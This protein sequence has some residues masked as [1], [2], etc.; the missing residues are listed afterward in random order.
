MAVGAI[1]AAA[2][3]TRVQKSLGTIFT[4]GTGLNGTPAH[5]VND[6]EH[7]IEETW[8]IFQKSPLIGYSLGGV[9]T[10]IGTLEGARITGNNDAKAM[11]GGAVFLEVLAASGGVGIIPFL[12]YLVFLIRKPLM[13]ARRTDAPTR[14]VLSGLVWALCM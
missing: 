8:E 7:A 1:G 3:S 5:S 12:L 14:E 2:T 11:E 9:A 13:A 10:A 6:R 4:G